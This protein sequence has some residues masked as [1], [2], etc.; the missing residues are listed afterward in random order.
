MEADA[1]SDEVAETVLVDSYF[2]VRMLRD[3]LR[4]GKV[5]VPRGTQKPGL[6]KLALEQKHERTMR[7]VE[8]MHTMGA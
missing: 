1:V 3:L 5:K 2:T 4:S 8:L 7:I 6:I